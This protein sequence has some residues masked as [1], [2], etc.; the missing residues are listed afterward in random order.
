MAGTKSNDCIDYMM[1]KFGAD[2][3]NGRFDSVL[4]SIYDNF[5]EVCMMFIVDK[6]NCPVSI[7]NK[8]KAIATYVDRGYIKEFD[9]L[10]S[11]KMTRALNEIKSRY[12]D[13]MM[14]NNVGGSS[15]NQICKKIFDSNPDFYK[16]YKPKSSYEFSPEGTNL[17]ME[18]STFV[19]CSLLGRD[20]ELYNQLSSAIFNHT[21][22]SISRTFR[23]RETYSPFASM[24]FH[25]KVKFGGSKSLIHRT[26]YEDG[27]NIILGI[28]INM[29]ATGFDSARKRY[30][31]M[32]DRNSN[33]K[34]GNELKLDKFHD[35]VDTR[36]RSKN[37]KY[38]TKKVDKDVVIHTYY[39]ISS[40]LYYKHNL[41][42][43]DVHMLKSSKFYGK[44]ISSYLSGEKDPGG[45]VFAFSSMKTYMDD[46]EYFYKCKIA[47]T[48]TTLQ[49]MGYVDKSTNTAYFI[50]RKGD[51]VNVETG[52][53]V[54]SDVFSKF[55]D[56]TYK[57]YDIDSEIAG[58][59]PENI[60]F[61]NST[62]ETL[63]T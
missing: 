15:V 42:G 35:I 41:G 7:K 16:E 8:I 5:G 11:Y 32:S 54:D 3:V 10:D 6:K 9:N 13:T 14:L 28:D 17:M 33:A 50:N 36:G 30:K 2:M 40:G 23:L 39:N 62:K 43:V 58:V 22:T 1:Y 26:T 61:I 29:Y 18:Y 59:S 46:S 38:N 12:M 48:T 56:T 31:E 37:Y 47:L 45:I 25:D 19:L 20:N 27:K 52:R 44:D 60:L 21:L 51:A 63:L 49:N 4:E 34:L 53:P 24:G 57:P 55:R